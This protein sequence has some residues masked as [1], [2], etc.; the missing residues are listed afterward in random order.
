MVTQR[1]GRPCGTGPCALRKITLV[2]YAVL[3]PGWSAVIPRS[4]LPN[5]A[6]VQVDTSYGASADQ[7]RSAADG[8][9]AGPVNFS[10]ETGHLPGQGRQG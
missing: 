2:A 6:G 1:R 7:S 4:T 10:V 9:P 8:K 3:E 5:R